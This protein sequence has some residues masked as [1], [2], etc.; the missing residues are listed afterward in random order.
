MSL[1]RLCGGE[2]IESKTDID[3]R[4]YV[5]FVTGRLPTSQVYNDFTFGESFGQLMS[6]IL[7]HAAVTLFTSPWRHF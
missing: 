6:P 7:C 2:D 5:C 4:G 3:P 1:Q